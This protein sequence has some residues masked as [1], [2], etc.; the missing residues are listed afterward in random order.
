MSQAIPRT[1][2]VG[3][4]FQNPVDVYINIVSPASS[5]TP[6]ADSNCLILDSSGQPSSAAGWHVG[7]VEGPTAISF[8][9]KVNE[10]MDD[11]HDAP[12]DAGFDSI[13]GEIDFNM[14]E[15]NLPHMQVLFTVD[16]MSNYQSY[17]DGEVLQVGGQFSSSTNTVSILLVSQRRDAAGKFIYVLAYKCYL[18]SAMVLNFIRSKESVY[19]LKF[20]VISDLARS[21][22]DEIMQIVRQK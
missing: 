6:T 20:G 18:K 1:Y 9:E 13:E 4:I 19:K 3:N 22:G 2:N 21:T 5:N 10:I 11:Q 8:T 7:S 15:T 17:F 16:G 12:I 14:K